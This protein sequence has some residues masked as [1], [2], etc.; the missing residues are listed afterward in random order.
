M[1]AALEEDWLF[2]GITETY[3]PLLETFDRLQGERIPF[4]LTVSLSPTLCEMLQDPLL[5]ARY[6]DHLERSIAL[7]SKEVDRLSNHAELAPVAR[8]YLEWFQKAEYLFEE[9][10]NKDLLSAFRRL[11]ES[12]SIALI[13]T[14]ATHAYLPL[15]MNRQTA[16]AQIRIAIDYFEKLFGRRPAGFWLPECGFEP[17]FDKILADEGIEYFFVDA[18]GLLSARPAPPFGTM[19]PVS[20]D[21]GIA[22]FG[23]DLESSRQ[24]WN[25]NS[26]YPGHPDYRDFYRDQGYELPLE[27]LEEYL[28]PYGHRKMT[29]MKYH[30]ITGGHGEKDLYN[31]DRARALAKEHASD[32]VQSRLRQAQAAE[33]M[34]SRPPL[35][36]APFDAE[37]FGHWWHEGVDF[38]EELIRIAASH[39][40]LELVTAHDYLKRHPNLDKASVASSSWGLGGHSQMWLDKSNDWIYIHLHKAAGRMGELARKYAGADPVLKRALD[41]GARELLLAQS[42]D[43]PFMMK[44][45]AMSGYATRRVEE[46]LGNFNSLREQILSGAI[47]TVFLEKLEESHNIF[48]GSD[49][50]VFSG[51]EPEELM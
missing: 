6:A 51:Y 23:R 32:F 13:T 14:C 16:L 31:M 22:V 8:M 40:G 35:F 38:L 37:L 3:L 44:T 17:G 45:G 4:R 5:M 34:D 33:G 29:G 12:D 46:H 30:R 1:K 15:M 21:Q 28:A 48:P 2:E 9:Q 20:A 25:P 7:A 10:Y 36:V 43:W 26:G 42:S 11:W 49:F 24:I 27:H 50:S 19:A 41:Q 39:E 47:D 18:H